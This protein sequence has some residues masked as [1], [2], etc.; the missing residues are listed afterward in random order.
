MNRVSVKSPARAVLLLVGLLSSAPL[1]CS[2]RLTWYERMILLPQPRKVSGWVLD[3]SGAPIAGAH[4]DHS[5][6][7]DQEQLF[8]DEL[9]RFY[10]ETRAPA[11]VVRKQGFDG[12]AS[13]PISPDRCALR[14]SV[15]HRCSLAKPPALD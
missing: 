15:P 2:Q 14:S 7:H 3:P 12:S 1:L 4:I 13:L 5:D 10:V 6:A 11:L 8:T 9:G